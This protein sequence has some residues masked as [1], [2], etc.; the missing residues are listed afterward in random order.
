VLQGNNSVIRAVDFSS[1]GRWVATGGD[2]RIVRVWDLRAT[3]PT[4]PAIPLKWNSMGVIRALQFTPDGKW[5]A[6]AGDEG[7]V[8]L[9]DVATLTATNPTPTFVLWDHEG[10]V[11]DIDVSPDSQWLISGSED[12][13]ARLWDL[14]VPDPGA[15]SIVFPGHT[16]PVWGVTISPDNQWFVTASQDG[17]ARLWQPVALNDVIR[18]A[19]RTSGRNL[20][21]E[22]WEYYVGVDLAAYHR[23]C[24]E[25]P[26]GADVP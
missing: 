17:N 24:P 26:K 16:G 2:D 5:L 12:E 25:F 19:C 10:S 18:S 11:R 13:T 7:A 9:W 20:S 21:R 6:T 23:T 4:T 1:D 14:T 3:D 22:E 8:L 15:Y